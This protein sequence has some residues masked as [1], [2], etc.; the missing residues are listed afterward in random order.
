MPMPMLGVVCGLKSEAA[1][2]AGLAAVVVRPTGA[3]P[4]A[5]AR[6]SW[7]LLA[8]GCTALVSFGTAGGLAPDLAPGTLV[9]A[10]AVVDGTG[11]RFAADA[12]AAAR[13]AAAAGDRGLAARTGAVAG[14]A[15]PLLTPAAKDAWQRTTGAIAVDMESLAVAAVATEAGV[16]FVVV[17]A[18]AD[19]AD[20]AVP[21]WVMGCIA[22][23]GSSRAG[24]VLARL[25]RHPADV[26]SLIRLAREARAAMATLRRVAPLLALPLFRPPLG[27]LG[28]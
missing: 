5:A 22:A 7:V 11:R 4:A 3:R 15:R 23:D 25:A 6:L 17:R 14:V 28:R 20:R 24:P 26:A 16:P 18:V 10:G 19:P 9:L 13:L 8:G 12:D 2:L 1:C 21:A 27:E